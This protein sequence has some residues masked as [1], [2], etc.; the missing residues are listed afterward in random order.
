MNI[1]FFLVIV[2]LFIVTVSVLNEKV[3]HM[4]SDIALLVS[5]VLFCCVILLLSQIPGLDNLKPLLHQIG[6]FG[7]EAYLLDF[8][9]CFMLFAGASKVN[10]GKFKQNIRAISL[11]AL[12]TTVLSS[13]IY[14]LLF[15]SVGMLFGVALDIWVCVLLGCIVSPTDPIAAT[16]I[17]NKLG[18]S[19][20][21]TSVIESESLFN[22]GTGVA[23]FVF[24][25]SIVSSKGAG[26]AGK[27]A[28]DGILAGGSSFMSVMLKE[29]LGA[30]VVA[31]VVSFL[32]FRLLKLTRDPA[33]HIMISLLDVA[34]V[35]LICEH[36]GFSG[37]IASVVCGMYFASEMH[38][39]SRRR[40]V[41]DPHD[42]YGA[43][44]ETADTMLNSMLFV[45]IGIS[46]LD[47]QLSS[48]L[49]FVIPAAIVCVILSRLAGV[50]LSTLFVGKRKIPSSYS[51]NEFVVLMTWSAL[52]G[53]L[54]LALAM[55]TK[56]FLEPEIYLMVLNAAYVTIF[57]TVI[58]QGLTVKMGYRMIEERKA[59]RI[60][61][62]SLSRKIE[63]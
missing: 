61:K 28:A 55:S 42:H 10:M 57:F 19:K 7:F 13:F 37:V 50:Y 44:W 3:I 14:G 60:R 46:L 54:S 58:G 22:D 11:L 18:L 59:K 38:K 4:Q 1:M 56:S 52:K 15:W 34:A 62:F 6:D 45:M 29:V 25:K 20:N 41:D 12:L 17:L 36:F 21:V 33:K 40:L 26:F 8:V 47:V 9:L 39:I 27:S 43:F 30:L 51:L 53:G 2:F 31:F 49:Y 5:S 35:Y 16:G 63:K 32:L 24:V 23:L 48:Y